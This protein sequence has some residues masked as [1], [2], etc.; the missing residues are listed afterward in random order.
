VA[1]IVLTDRFIKSRRSA[2]AGRRDE[3]ADA[4]MPGLVLMV[5]DTGHRSF[6]LRTRYPSHPKNP[7]RRALG[8]YGRL[9]LDKARQKASRWYELIGRGVD[10]AIEEERERAAARVIQVN[11][12]AAV[13]SEFLKRHASGLKKAD[14]AR[15]IIEREF[16]KPWA[17]RA[18]TDITPREVSAAIRAIVNRGAPYQ[19]HNALGYLRRLFNWAIGT[20]EFGIEQSPVERLKPADLIGK[21]EARERILSDTELRAVWQ[22]AEPMGY[23]YGPVFRML[24]LTGQ[25]EREVA[26]AS[27]PEINFEKALWTIPTA[28]M[29]GGR[30]HEVPLSPT[31]VAL[32]ESLPRWNGDFVFT[33]TGGQK[34]INGFSKAKA[35]IDKLSGVTDWKI[36]DLRRSMRTHLS[37]LP[38]QDLVRELV[39]AHARPGLHKVYDQ[40]SYQLE[41]QQCLELWE[42]RLLGIVDPAPSTVTDLAK[43]RAERVN[44]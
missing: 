10:P 37:A 22:A 3:Y 32:L 41:K 6:V 35:R 38:V 12:F 23:P 27:W 33:T 4:L 18:I 43:A 39:I 34:P 42:K 28:R 24:I 20:H 15:K 25:R 9:S 11:T 13:A 1:K 30:A 40:H 36:H 14:E 16:I 2:E 29:K 8:T 44:S 7:T 17:G 19:A 5:T 26:D 31:A 21:R